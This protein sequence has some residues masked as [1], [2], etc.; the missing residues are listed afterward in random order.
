MLVFDTHKFYERLEKSGFTKEQ[1]ETVTDLVKE[2]QESSF[3]GIGEKLATKEDI[4][5]SK[6]DLELKI[7]QTKSDLE[8]KIQQTKSD[9]ELKIQQTK[10]DLI[11]WIVGGILTVLLFNTGMVLTVVRVFLK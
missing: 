9:L 6:S 5:V 10:I 7:Q 1:A 4:L 3:R 11:K 2:T 8:L